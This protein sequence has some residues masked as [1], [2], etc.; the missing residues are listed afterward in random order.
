MTTSL[1]IC[2]LVIAAAGS[3]LAA[4]HPRRVA[5]VVYDGAEIL[6]VAGP[7]EVLAVA[8]Q[9]AGDDRGQALEVYT[10]ARTTEPITA[11]GFIKIVPQ[12]AIGDAPRPDVVVVPG[13]DVGG[14]SDDPQMMTWLT[15]ASAASEATLAVC[16]GALP[17]AER[18]VYDGLEITTWV[19][20]IDDLR[21]LAPKAR[22][23]QGRRFIDNGRFITT[24]G[25][26]AGI[27]G[28][29]H[30]VARLFGRRVADQTARYMEYRW[31]PEPYLADRYTYW[32]PSTDDLGRALQAAAAAAEEKRWPEAIATL[33][34]VTVNDRTG[35]AWLSLG[36]V[37]VR[38]GDPKGAIETYR[39]VGPNE[40]VYRKAVYRLARTY[41]LVGDKASA[42][43]TL[44][45][46]LRAGV[47]REQAMADP[48]LATIKD[49]IPQLR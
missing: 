24:A 33:R 32:N 3:A 10:V 20:A 6:D 12:Y 14:L 45:R 38:S 19:D 5:I 35:V 40:P 48:G 34:K 16:T 29:L 41:A 1:L 42:L 47:D 8:D 28:S 17:L 46:A 30:L 2:G 43:A 39:K 36:G 21:A 9:F 27:D 18:G 22:V 11:Q 49:Q 4:P 26:S 31:T 37:L 7:A 44:A 23:I 25:V 15:Q 13:G